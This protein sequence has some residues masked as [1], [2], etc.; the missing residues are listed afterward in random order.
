M[1]YRLRRGYACGAAIAAALVL[2]PGIGSTQ[3]TPPIRTLTEQE[4]VDMM[5][6]S[7]IQATRSSNSASMIQRVR[8]AVKQ[9]RKFTMISVKDL[10][11]DWQIAVPSA[12]GGGGAWEHVLEEVR[13]SRFPSSKGER[14]VRHNRAGRPRRQ[15]REEETLF[16][17]AD[18]DRLKAS[19]G[20]SGRR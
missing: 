7:S 5:V 12:V 13:G 20:R 11:D 14:V 6:G 16:R 4:M 3:G 8:D 17:R 9:G 15:C 18:H 19:R 2:L 10:P 1:F